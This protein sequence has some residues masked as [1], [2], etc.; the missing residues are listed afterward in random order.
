MCL[1][2]YIKLN[3]NTTETVFDGKLCPE[4]FPALTA[5]REKFDSRALRRASLAQD[6]RCT[7]M[8]ET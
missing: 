5:L 2:A 4:E 7:T 3:H 6:L 8:G 1:R